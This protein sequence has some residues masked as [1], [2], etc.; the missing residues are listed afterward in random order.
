MQF[1]EYKWRKANAWRIPPENENERND[2]H[3]ERESD[4][5]MYKY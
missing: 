4:E 2:T 5:T 1:E 3:N